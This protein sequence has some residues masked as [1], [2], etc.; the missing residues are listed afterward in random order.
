MRSNYRGFHWDAGSSDWILEVV[1]ASDDSCTK[2][3]SNLFELT[4]AT[5]VSADYAI[6]GHPSSFN[7]DIVATGA[8]LS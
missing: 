4:A 2:S 7:P 1:N 6:Y 5:L 3:T 8:V